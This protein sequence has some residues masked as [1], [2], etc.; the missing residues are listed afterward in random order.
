MGQFACCGKVVV[1]QCNGN[2]L[3]SCCE[4]NPSKSTRTS[5]EDLKWPQPTAQQTCM[6]RVLSLSSKRKR[7]EKKKEPRRDG[8]VR[9]RKR[10]Y[11]SQSETIQGANQQK[12]QARVQRCKA[13]AR[14]LSELLK[15]PGTAVRW[16][17]SDSASIPDS[18]KSFYLEYPP[19]RNYEQNWA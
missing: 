7:V 13:E 9:E 12:H 4:V 1:A 8:G 11:V 3:H 16:T 5:W 15:E 17:Q 6:I 2:Q 19:G 18:R 14:A 10:G